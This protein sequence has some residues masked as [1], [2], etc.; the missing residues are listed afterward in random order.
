MYTCVLWMID[1]CGIWECFW[2][3]VLVV[4]GVFGW[5]FVV[6]GFWYWGFYW[7]MVVKDVRM[8]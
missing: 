7:G 8:V 6:V 2:K 3:W 5:G 4:W 1:R